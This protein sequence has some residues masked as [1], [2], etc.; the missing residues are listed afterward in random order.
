MRE[1]PGFWLRLARLDADRYREARQARPDADA[2]D[3]QAAYRVGHALRASRLSRRAAR[4]L[5]QAA[6]GGVLEAAEDLAALLRR[7]RRRSEAVDWYRRAAEM[8]RD[9]GLPAVRVAAH[10]RSAFE[11]AEATRVLRDAAE[12]GDGSAASALGKDAEIA[13]SPTEAANWYR[14]AIGL[15]ATSGSE[16]LRRLD[17][18]AKWLADAEAEDRPRAEGG[19]YD[20]AMRLASTLREMGRVEEAAEWDERSSRIWMD[21]HHNGG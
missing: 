8:A 20:A 14:M 11:Y 16:G 19:D 12:Q 10:Y 15:G 21:Y 18:R 2:G 13:G 9:Q 6:D 17:N 1:S 4:Y 3:A 5:R 7:R